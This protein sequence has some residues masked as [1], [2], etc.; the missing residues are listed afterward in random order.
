MIDIYVM[1]IRKSLKEKCY[2]SALSLALTLPDICGMAEYPQKSSVARRYIDWYDKYL[3]WYM[4]EGHN[5]LG[6]DNPWLSGEVIYNLRNTYL[7]QGS[8]NVIGSKVK[9][10]S[11]QLDRFILILGDG[12][13]IQQMTLSI[14]VGHGN[15]TYKNIIVDITY[16]CDNLCGCALEYYK[17]N[18]EKFEFDFSI[19]TQEELLDPKQ[20]SG[21]VDIVAKA[22]NKKLI[23][24]GSTKQIVEKPHDNIIKRMQEGFDIIFSNENMKKRFLSGDST[25]TF[26]RP[27]PETIK[28]KSELNSN[29]LSKREAQVRSFFG[30]HFKKKIYID[31]KEEIIQSVLEAGT[32]QQV[33][34]NL[35]RY[36]RSEDVKTIYQRLQPLIKNM[37][38]K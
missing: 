22:L 11:N 19:I 23:E 33:N 20:E 30:R 34:N 3:G 31:K 4:A 14:D 28:N 18:R 10:S 16:L 32:K 38:R 13:V 6:G 21:D 9:K 15:L 27:A 8:P 36:F 7:H 35:M 5:D 1:D 37:P 25:I 24:S 29:M 2:F 26:T 12:T 17:N